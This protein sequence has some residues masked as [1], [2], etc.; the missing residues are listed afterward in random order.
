MPVTPQQQ[1]AA[2]PRSLEMEASR[3]FPLSMLP[4][5]NSMDVIN[6]PR[7]MANSVIA[8]RLAAFQTIC[9]VAVLM[10]NLSVQQMFALE[11][12]DIKLATVQGA[13][14]YTGFILMSLVFLMNLGVCI[15]LIQQLFMTYR[16]LTAGATGFEVAK[17]YYLH[18]DIVSM[19]HV[20][21][22]GFFFSLPLFLAASTCMVFKSFDDDGKTAL[23]IP[24]IAFFALAALVLWYLNHRNN[25]IFKDRYNACKSHE[26]PLLTQLETFSETKKTGWWSNLDA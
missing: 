13:I 18:P 11:K 26:E 24:V 15:V 20:S 5:S 3:T 21:V 10:V 19:R 6:D 12:A 2:S 16:L 7:F 17:S 23:A 22:K 9:V 1:V 14:T 4:R 8:K 25:K